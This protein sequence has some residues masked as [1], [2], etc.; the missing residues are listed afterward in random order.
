[1][2][3]RTAYAAIGDFDE[4]FVFLYLRN[5]DIFDPDIVFA[6]EYRGF[7]HCFHIPKKP[8]KKIK[9]RKNAVKE[10]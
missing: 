4:N 2:Y 5:G 6:V 9:K 3:I 8:P 10:R 1:M 7:H